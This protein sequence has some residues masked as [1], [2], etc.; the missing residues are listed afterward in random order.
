[1]GLC[2]GVNRR[3]QLFIGHEVNLAVQVRLI[4]HHNLGAVVHA[5]RISYFTVWAVARSHKHASHVMRYVIAFARQD[6]KHKLLV[7][8]EHLV[9]AEAVLSVHQKNFANQLFLW[10]RIRTFHLQ[11]EN[12]CQAK[13]CRYDTYD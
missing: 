9:G 13:E 1:M 11:S 2:E 12:Q 4:T 3:Y 6:S 8:D 5:S 7:S 10:Y